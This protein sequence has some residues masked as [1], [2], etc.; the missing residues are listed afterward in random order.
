MLRRRKTHNPPRPRVNNKKETQRTEAIS[1]NFI[2]QHRLVSSMA[3]SR[4]CTDPNSPR[5][6]S[7]MMRAVTIMSDA[8]FS[9]G[10]SVVGVAL[11]TV[12]M[13]TPTFHHVIQRVTFNPASA[14][15]RKLTNNAIPPFCYDVL[16]PASWTSFP[17]LLGS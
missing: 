3:C 14:E 15:Q 9:V 13:T 4:Q 17:F 10:S 12:L 7:M 6:V 5:K 8:T 2:C 11:P 16:P 1:L